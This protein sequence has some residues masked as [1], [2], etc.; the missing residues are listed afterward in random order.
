V[1]DTAVG[2][3]EVVLGDAPAAADPGTPPPGS[4]TPPTGGFKMPIPPA[5]APSHPR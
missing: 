5:S 2:L 4:G 1:I 3:K